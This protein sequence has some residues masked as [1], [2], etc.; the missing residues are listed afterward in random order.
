MTID[1]AQKKNNTSKYAKIY[2]LDLLKDKGNSHKDL[3]AVLSV[4][5]NT[6]Q[7]DEVRN[8]AKEILP[9]LKSR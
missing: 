2:A 7:L 1:P 8:K 6:E 3:E 9:E 4:I 5:N